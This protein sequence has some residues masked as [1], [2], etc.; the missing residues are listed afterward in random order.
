M[1]DL[2]RDQPARRNLADLVSKIE[3]QQEEIRVAR[4]LQ[5]LP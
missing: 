2:P 1:S 3:R 5:W 4:E